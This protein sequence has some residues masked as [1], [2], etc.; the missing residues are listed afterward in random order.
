MQASKPIASQIRGVHHTAVCV[1]DFSNAKSFYTGFLGFEVEAEMVARD[2]PALGTVVGLSGAVVDWAMLRRGGQRLELFAYRS[3]NGTDDP[4]L[5]C[6]VGYTH[7]AMEVDDVDLAYQAVTEAGYACLSPP[8]ELR[9]GRTKVFYMEG[10]E[11]VVVEFI[12]LR[13][14]GECA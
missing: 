12:E 10:P 14:T 6:D 1:R 11:R 13:P 9:G 3:H 4:G 5:Q 2:E 8:Q 7:M